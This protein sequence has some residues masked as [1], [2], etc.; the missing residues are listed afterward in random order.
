LYFI[1][2]AFRR[3][4]QGLVNF[5]TGTPEEGV[6]NKDLSSLT[7]YYVNPANLSDLRVISEKS[8]ILHAA[9]SINGYQEPLKPLTSQ[10]FVNKSTREYSYHF[11]VSEDGHTEQLHYQG[12]ADGYT[13]HK[14]QTSSLPRTQLKAYT[15]AYYSPELDKTYHLSVRRGKLGL[16]IF[17]LFHIP[18]QAMEGNLFLADLMGSNSLVF[19]KDASQK[20]TGFQFSREGVHQLKFIKK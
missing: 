3:L 5:R 6:I 20:I 17:Y 16:R 2:F 14:L 1:V 11:T 19:T 8:I 12:R 13:L 15:G 9:R 4:F 10:R 18:F 7:G